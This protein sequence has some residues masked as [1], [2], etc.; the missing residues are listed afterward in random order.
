MGGKRMLQANE[1]RFQIPLDISVGCAKAPAAVTIGRE[2]AE[3]VALPLVVV[4][5][6]AG[7]TPPQRSFGSTI[8][9]YPT[10]PGT[11]HHDWASCRHPGYTCR[12]EATWV[13]SGALVAS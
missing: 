2:L 4:M 10:G 9:A 11:T 13:S 3:D 6:E 12:A 7:G 1:R 5:D 8:A